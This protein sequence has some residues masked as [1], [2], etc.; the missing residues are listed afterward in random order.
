MAKFR[1]IWSHWIRKELGKGEKW[2]DTN[3][4]FKSSANRCWIE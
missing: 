2:T 3:L 4:L 1:Q